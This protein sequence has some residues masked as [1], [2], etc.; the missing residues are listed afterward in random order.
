[1]QDGSI[2]DLT[3]ILVK[4]A[5]AAEINAA[6]KAAAAGPLKGLMK[7][8]EDPIVSSDV[9][10][11]PSSCVIDALSTQVLGNLV[12][13]L[14]WYDNEWGYSNRCVELLERMA[15]RRSSLAEGDPIQDSGATA[16]RGPPGRP[17]GVDT[18]GQLAPPP[19]PPPPPPPL[20]LGIRLPT[21]RC[22]SE[23]AR[24][25]LVD[26]VASGRAPDYEF[27]NRCLTPLDGGPVGLP[28]ATLGCSPGPPMA[29]APPG[30]P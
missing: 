26:G 7:Y 10:G 5:T 22:R 25:H 11:D 21:R 18:L 12:K 23:G 30:P 3:A 19:P 20:P 24:H 13:V 8:T 6:L 9:I 16:G 15:P 2:V 17:E 28:V 1:V 14:A 27:A 4:P 29:V